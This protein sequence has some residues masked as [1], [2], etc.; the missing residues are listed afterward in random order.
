VDVTVRA[1]QPTDWRTLRGVRLVSLLDAPEAFWASHE[2]EVGM[3][4]D[5]WRA[6]AS[7][8]SSFLAFD[9][10]GAAV[11]TATGIALP[12]SSPHQRELVG[13]W[14]APVVRG[15][16]IAAPLIEAVADWARADGASELALWVVDG[17]DGARRVYERAGFVA[18]GERQPFPGDDPRIESRM[19]RRLG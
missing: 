4:E 18:T 5:A 3:T 1:V 14:V 15:R 9:E 11:G 10:E 7:G 6:R 13:M 2:Q 8:G 12:G 19:V 17:N 16:G